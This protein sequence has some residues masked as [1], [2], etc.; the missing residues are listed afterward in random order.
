MFANNKDSMEK[1]I[2]LVSILWVLAGPTAIGTPFSPEEPDVYAVVLGIAQDGGYPQIGC[3]RKCC[4]IALKSPDERKFVS[5]IAIV[6]RISQTRYLFDCTPDFPKQFELLNAQTPFDPNE[7]IDGIFLTHAHVGH[8]TGLIHFG[9]EILGADRVP[10]Y[11]TQTMSRFLSHNGPWSQLV[12]LKNIELKS[13]VADTAIVLSS[14]VK[15]TAFKVPHRDEFTDTVG[16]KIEGPQR[17]LV[18]LPDID[19]WSRWERRIEDLVNDSDVALLDGTFMANGEI[20]GRNMSEIPH[21][22]I[23]ESLVRF[24]TLPKETRQRIKFIHLNHTNPA[25]RDNGNPKTNRAARRIHQAGLGLAR[26]G[27][28]ISLSQMP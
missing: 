5:S 1:Q 25:I 11:S 8:Y 9:R 3:E 27:E 4:E 17:R 12:K 26:Q 7:V 18:F 23:E 13:F 10:V 24:A 20:P 22:F 6:D 15:V 16:F 21:P 19:K 14:R 2:L 28:I